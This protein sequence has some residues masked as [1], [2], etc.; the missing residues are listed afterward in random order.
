MADNTQVLLFGD[1]SNDFVSELR[2]LFSVKDNPILKEF[3]EQAHYVV[4]AQMIE[5]LPPHE[6]KASRTADLPQ[7][8]Q[9]YVEG[10]LSPA[11]QV[12]L[13]C[14]AQLGSCMR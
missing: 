10:K 13:S 12:V 6:H 7:M 4:R 3:F 9:K 14:I 5:V 8:L 11:F 2:G 1:L